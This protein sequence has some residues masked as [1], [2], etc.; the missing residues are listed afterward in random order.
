M[1]VL[2]FA[3]D[4]NRPSLGEDVDQRAGEPGDH[5]LTIEP[6]VGVKYR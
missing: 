2:R 6:T 4:D 1:K 3:Q 5:V